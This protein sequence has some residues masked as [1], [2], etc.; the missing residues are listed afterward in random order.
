[1]STSA[2]AVINEAALSIGDPKFTRVT[3]NDWRDFLNR[4]CRDMAR[5]LRLVKRKATFDIVAEQEYALPEDCVQVS[6]MEYNDTPVDKA[7]WF[8]VREKFQDDFRDATDGSYASGRPDEYFAD[9][10]TFYLYPRPD[11]AVAA[12]GRITY[13]GMP[14]EVTD[15]AVQVLPIRDVLR[16]TLRE[17]MEV[18]GLRRL[19]RFDKA[20]KAEEEWLASLTTDRDRL[21][22]RSADRR[23]RLRTGVMSFGER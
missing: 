5:K 15:E 22:D 8:E 9:T 7:T 20:Q 6:R 11:V 1:M 13:W 23:A 18:Y 19:E 3:R 10:D 4:S 12:G 2:L 17:R 14:D 21:E 16:D